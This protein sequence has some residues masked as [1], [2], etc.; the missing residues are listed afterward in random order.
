MAAVLS[1]VIPGA[2]QI[3]NGQIGKGLLILIGVPLLVVFSFLTLFITLIVALV[4]WLW[5]IFDAYK[6]AERINSEAYR[7]SNQNYPGY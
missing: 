3:Y 4:V 1:L 7:T 5:G 2:G 6:T